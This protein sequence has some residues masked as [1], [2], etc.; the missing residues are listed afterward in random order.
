[1]GVQKDNTGRRW[2]EVEIEVSGTPEEVWEA[3]ASGPGISSWF[4]ATDM[5]S[6]AD[7]TPVKVV[8]H[9]GPGDSMDSVAEITEWEP[10]RRF[11]AK[12]ADLGPDAPEIATEWIVEARSGSTCNVRVVHSLV[13]DTS[14]WDDQL[15]A[16]E[17]GWPWFFQLLRLYLA[18]FSGQPCAAYRVMGSAAGTPEEAWTSFAGYLGVHDKEI[19]EICQSAGGMPPLAGTVKQREEGGHDHAVLV[20]LDEPAAGILSAF[21]LPMDGAVY[22]V[23]DVFHYG[24]MAAAAEQWEPRWQAWMKERFPMPGEQDTA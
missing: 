21:V 5:E 9:F 1:M 14:D 15:G 16:W 8:S 10:P 19:G 22:L 12:S 2:V 17:G 4:V 3:I 13:T 23:M 11:V 20:R 18:H 6:G 24:K 7:G